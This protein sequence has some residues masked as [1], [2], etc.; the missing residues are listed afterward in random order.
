[1]LLSR[2]LLLAHVA[3]LAI[4]LPAFAQDA[5]P[6]KPAP[7]TVVALAPAG[8]TLPI[9][10]VSLYRSGVGA[11]ERRGTV[12]GNAAR[13][14]DFNAEYLNDVLKSLQLL[15]LD[16]GR[17]SAVSFASRDPLARRLDGFSVPIADAPSLSTLLG[18]LRGAA[19]TL[20]LPGESVE[21]TILS[22]EAREVA[23]TVRDRGPVVESFVNLVTPAGLRSLAIANVSTFALKDPALN[24]DLAKALAAVADNRSERTRTL[25]LALSGTGERRLVVRYVHETPVWKTSY[26]LLIPDDAEAAAVK[27]T[28][29]LQGWAIVENTTDADWRDVRLSLVSG[30]PVSFRMDLSAPLYLARPEVP[31][32]TVP[33]A[34]PREFAGGVGAG[35]PLELSSP[36]AAAP[37]PMVLEARRESAQKARAR[38][39]AEAAAGFADAAEN[40]APRDLSAADLLAASPA[41]IATAG[42]SGEVFFYEVDTPVT[43]ERRRSAMIPFLSSPVAARRVSILSASDPLHPMRGVELTNSSS[44]QLLPG[45]LAVYDGAA[46]TGDA[47]IGQIPP[48]D[49]RLL[50]YALDLDLTVQAQSDQPAEVTRLRIVSGLIEQTSRTVARTTYTLASRDQRR[51]RTIIIEQPRLPGYELAEPAKPLETT[52]DLYR[53]ETTLPPGQTGTFTIRQERTDKTNLALTSLDLPTLLRYE[54]QGKASPAVVA[55]FQK[56]AALQTT[57]AGAERDLASLDEQLTRAGQEQERISRTMGPLPQNSE[58]YQTYLKDLGELNTSSKALRARRPAAAAAVDT[59]RRDLAEGARLTAAD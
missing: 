3:G 21:G 46:Y 7:P 22:V 49:K 38:G 59:A 56:L 57:L 11:F 36:S 1:M 14:L 41:S 19:V 32:P 18:R 12:A 17:V 54:Q 24:A 23:S 28:M 9:T 53:F 50:A 51:P 47:Q 8:E 39:R 5:A 26:R 15:D 13:A 31:V 33:G 43:I 37:A 40:S 27:G 35:L 25:D 30:R 42:E 2:S 44:L 52:Q 48:G 55:A 16:G 45:P 6:P 4:A 20:A 29:P 58:V 10:R 34:M